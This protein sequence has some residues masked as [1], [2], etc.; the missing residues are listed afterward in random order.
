MLVG[1]PDTGPQTIVHIQKQL[2]EAG[3][4]KH[5]PGAP[6]KVCSIRFSIADISDMHRNISMTGILFR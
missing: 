3:V 4:E 6:Q 1:P 5:Q 2:S